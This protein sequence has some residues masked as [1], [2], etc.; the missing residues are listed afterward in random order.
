MDDDWIRIQE[1]A[2]IRGEIESTTPEPPFDPNE[3]WSDLPP[4]KKVPPAVVFNL[5]EVMRQAGIPLKGEPRSAGLFSGGKVNVTLRV[6]TRLIAEA[7]R[8]FS[9]HF[10]S[11]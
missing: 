2:R 5:M 10:G 8:I 6:P 9:S 7:E 1:E 11:L 4:L 3:P